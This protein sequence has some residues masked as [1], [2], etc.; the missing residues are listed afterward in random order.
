MA[1]VSKMPLVSYGC[2]RSEISREQSRAR[3]IKG[4]QAHHEKTLG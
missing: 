2:A 1:E 4:V 3:A